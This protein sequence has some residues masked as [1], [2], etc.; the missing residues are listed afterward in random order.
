[1]RADA[2]SERGL[3]AK[4]F[5]H[6]FKTKV[7]TICTSGDLEKSFEGDIWTCEGTVK[8]LLPGP[9]KNKMGFYHQMYGGL[10]F[11]KQY[12]LVIIIFTDVS[13]SS[14]YSIEHF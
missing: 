4:F 8:T 2:Y 7:P 13:F 9:T 12:Y 6:M 10:P 3:A 1:M 11:Y 14:L 5:G